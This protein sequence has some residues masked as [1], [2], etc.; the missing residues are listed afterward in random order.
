MYKS[1]PNPAERLVQTAVF[2]STLFLVISCSTPEANGGN[3]APTTVPPTGI[4]SKVLKAC[5]AR[6]MSTLDNGPKD[7]DPRL[8]NYD[9]GQTNEFFAEGYTT[10]EDPS[11]SQSPSGV[12]YH[13]LTT[14]SLCLLENI[15]ADGETPKLGFRRYTTVITSETLDPFQSSFP[16]WINQIPQ[17]NLQSIALN[18]SLLTP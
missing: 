1:I 13:M 5:V 2:G 4:P 12:I 3:I 11:E 18:C 17:G 7:R 10:P 9:D 14:S 8:C 6:G 15:A 16:R